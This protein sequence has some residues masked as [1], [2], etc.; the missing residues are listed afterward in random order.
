MKLKQE[1]IVDSNKTATR[2]IA[3]TL[4]ELLVVIAIIAIL[5]SMLLP[6][7]ANAKSKALRTS[8]LNN[9]KQIQILAQMYTDDYI[10]KFPPCAYSYSDYDLDNNWWGP[11]L[12]NGKTNNY[13]LFHDPAING[14]I[15]ENG[16]TW[17]WKF[18]FDLVSY[19]YNS[20]FLGSTP[21]PGGAVQTVGSCKFTSSANFKRSNIV[22]PVNCLTFGDK[23]PKKDGTASASLWWPKACVGPNSTSQEYEGIDV[24]R[25][26]GGKLTGVGNVGFADGHAEGRKDSKINP[27]VDPQTGDPRGV[28]NSRYWDPLQ[29]GGQQ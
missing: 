18:D 11:L 14:T 20:F 3:F 7:L 28:I 13:K 2:L 1:R 24:R 27:P 4:I 25:H 6:A 8:C 15:S 17:S 16:A 26:D 23:Q 19:G 29:R 22:S 10:D 9:F 21:Q 12:C 5:A